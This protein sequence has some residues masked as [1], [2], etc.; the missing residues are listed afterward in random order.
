MLTD[1]E[2]RILLAY[3]DRPW[4]GFRKVRKGV[5]KRVRRHMEEL[6][7]RTFED[8]ILEMERRPEVRVECE[9]RLMV[10][11]SRFF[12]DRQLWQT[13]AERLLPDLIARFQ[14][15]VRIWSAGCANGEEAYSLAMV[16]HSLPGAP[17]LK[18]LATDADVRCLDRARSGVYACSSLK[19]VP[20]DLRALFFDPKRGR[21]HFQIKTRLLTR[22]DW[23]LHQLLDRP[24]PGPY[25]AILLRNNL[26][27]YHQG[28][29]LQA[30]LERILT[31]LTP[32]GYLVLGSHEKPPPSFL[33]LVRDQYCPWAYQF[34]PNG[35]P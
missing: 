4:T 26:L 2:F 7:H 15:P 6:G 19:E 30:A 34:I 8:Y 20:D 31:V 33:Q 22:I 32:G 18:L 29:S 17:P 27:T 23:Q 9:H 35:S 24:P 5:K 10:T 21:R 25:H 1:E 28:P 12:R 16:W 14:A 3:L 11:I 13:C